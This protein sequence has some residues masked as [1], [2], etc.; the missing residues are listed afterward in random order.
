MTSVKIKLR[1]SADRGRTGTVYFQI[2]HNRSIRQIKTPYR[3]YPHEWDEAQS[4]VI[5]PGKG[6]PRF[7]YLSDTR[8]RLMQQLHVFHRVIASLEASGSAFDSDDVIS[9]FMVRN[10][11]YN[12][13]GFMENVIEGLRDTGKA[14]S[15]E[16]YASTLNSFRRFRNGSDVLLDDIDADLLMAYEAWLKEQNVSPNSSSFYMRNLR[17]VYNRAVEKGYTDQRTP[18]RHV[19]TGIDKTVKRAVSEKTIRKIRALDLSNFP[20]LDFAR[21]IFMFSFYTRGMSFVDIAYLKKRDLR[22][23]VLTYRRRK[24]GQ[25]LFIKWEDCMEKIVRKH[26]IE[27]SEYMLPIIRD[28]EAARG[29]YITVAHNVNRNLKAIGEAISL[30]EPLTMYV[31]RHTWAS[32]AKSKNI[33]VSIIS[34]GMGHD[35]ESTTQIY[36]ASIDG[37]VIDKANSLILK[38]LQGGDI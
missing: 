1:S 10:P 29:Q 13:F 23:G 38:S 19:Y 22:G 7:S 5:V 8:T 4:R 21:D 20:Q 26:S 28:V 9:E 6:E 36:L 15:A 18:F 30:K 2:I 3:L 16:S 32:I 17:A 24:T 34:E 12:L 27:E 11:R 35:R 25:L 37:V 31:A 14:R 33:P